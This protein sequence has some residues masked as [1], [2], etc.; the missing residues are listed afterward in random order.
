MSVKV[1][2]KFQVVIPEEA[3][4][5][6]NLKPGMEVEVIV[7]G[8]IAYLVPLKTLAELK[9]GLGAAWNPSDR[10]TIREKKNRKV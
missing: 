3:R 9:K 8:G 10:Q 4:K 7:K 1:S 5:A 2:P 6:L